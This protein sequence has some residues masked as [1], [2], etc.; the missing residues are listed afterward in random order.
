MSM[1]QVLCQMPEIHGDEENA[2]LSEAYSLGGGITELMSTSSISLPGQTYFSVAAGG[3]Y[4]LAFGRLK[5]KVG[6]TFFK[7]RKCFQDCSVCQ[8]NY[9]ECKVMGCFF[10]LIFPWI[11]ALSL[12]VT[13]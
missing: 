10:P 9:Q 8:C 2:C 6:H 7:V 3:I 1:I 11:K 13:D 12:P 5:N 4:R